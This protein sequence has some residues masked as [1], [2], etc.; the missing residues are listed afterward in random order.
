MAAGFDVVIVGAGS[1]GCVLAARLSEVTAC[2]VLLVEVGPDY[3]AARIPADLADGIHGTSTASHDWGLRGTGSAEAPPLNL[4]RGRVTGGSSAVNATFALRGHPDD[5]DG[6][7]LPGWAFADVLASFVRLERDLDFG[8]VDYHGTDGPLPV[9]RYVG[10]ERSALAAAT[11]DAF[12]SVGIPRVEDHNAPGA[13]GVAALP[14]NCLDGRRISTAIA[15][16]E[17]ARGRPNLAIR[18]NCL[19]QEVVVRN[20]RAAG[21]R[22][23]GSGEVIPADEVIICAGAYQSPGLLIRS[24]IGP[25]AD[26][27]ALGITVLADLPGVGANLVDHPAVSID[28]PCGRPAGDPAIFQLVATTRSGQAGGAGRAPDLQLMICGPYNSD[29]GYACSLAAALLKPISRGRIRLSSSDAAVAPD[30]DLGYFRNPNDAIRLRE[31][32]RLADSA[33]QTGP[34]AGITGGTRFGPPRDVICDDAAALA[35]IRASA[36]TYHHPVGSCAMG[37]DPATGAVVDP[38]GRVYGV[39][40]LSVVDASIMPDI[41]SANTNIPTVM[42]AEHLAARRHADALNQKA[43]ASTR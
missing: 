18:A 14:V 5:Y 1:A 19:V 25:A 30:I 4:P 20:S 12:E 34:L 42:L 23:H 37:L 6:W 28:L 41:P 26:L 43:Q 17:A 10:A 13:V 16:L 35:W 31:C 38:S 29:G 21:I 40:G 22:V 24:G 32:L 8:T 39:A 11:Q 27:T 9:R 33:T 2:R 7:G 3:P 36:W 15:Y